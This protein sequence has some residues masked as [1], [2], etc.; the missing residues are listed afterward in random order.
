[1]TEIAFGSCGTE[2]R[3]LDRKDFVKRLGSCEHV[4]HGPQECLTDARD[5]N[6]NTNPQRGNG[7]KTTDMHRLAQGHTARPH[8]RWEHS[9]RLTSQNT[10]ASMEQALFPDSKSHPIPR[11]PFLQSPRSSRDWE[12]PFILPARYRQ[13]LSVAM[14]KYHPQLA[15]FLTPPKARMSR[16]Q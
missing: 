14:Q 15:L 16:W 1:M 6:L 10:E 12:V 11:G 13:S 5:S 4:T 7:E 9:I 2:K 8:Q 3:P